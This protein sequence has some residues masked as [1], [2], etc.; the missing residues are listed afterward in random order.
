MNQ[1]EIKKTWTNLM[2]PLIIGLIILVTAILFHQLG[3][4]RP[5]PQSISLFGC[6][7]GVIFIIAPLNK[8]IKFKKYLDSLKK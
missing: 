8:I 1:E 2:I 6:L 4:K 3:S 5:T 7:F